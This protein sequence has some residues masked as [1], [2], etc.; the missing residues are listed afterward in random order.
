MLKA[1]ARGFF[2]VLG[3]IVVGVCVFLFFLKTD[4]PI[5]ETLP[6]NETQAMKIFYDYP[7]VSTLDEM[8]GESEFIVIGRYTSLDS[9][10][11]MARNPDNIT[12]EDSENYVEGWLYNFEIDDVL[13]GNLESRTILVNHKYSQVITTTESNAVVDDEG[14]ILKAATEQNTLSFSVHDPMFIEPELD[15][16]YI[17]FLLKDKAFGNYY[18]AVEPF[19]IKVEN[20]MPELQSNLLNNTK[21]FSE[22]IAVGGDR[23]IDVLCDVGMGVEDFISGRSLEDIIQA[24]STSR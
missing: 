4:S 13:K 23:T 1:R 11:N 19:S 10:W 2:F 6:I 12:E 14:N 18:A 5:N 24:I 16:T 17:L 22:E 8:A 15:S 3:I 7:V 21:A 20:G 9:K